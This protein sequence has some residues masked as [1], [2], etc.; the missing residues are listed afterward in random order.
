MTV[1]IAKISLWFKNKELHSV[2]NKASFKKIPLG[3]IIFS[4]VFTVLQA[5]HSCPMAK[6]IHHD[7]LTIR[8]TFKAFVGMWGSVPKM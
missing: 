4:T 8:Y 7:I 3:L 6:F 2:A 5:N 1:I